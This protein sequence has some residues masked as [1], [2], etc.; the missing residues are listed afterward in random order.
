MHEEERNETSMPAGI[1]QRERQI[2]G[3]TSLASGLRLSHD[4]WE[5][6]LAETSLS[7]LQSK[8]YAMTRRP[9]RLM[10]HVEFDHSLLEGQCPAR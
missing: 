2:S 8:V 4:C 9:G 5:P 6:V 10:Y 1:R 7:A 3:S